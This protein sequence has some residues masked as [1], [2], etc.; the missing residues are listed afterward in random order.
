MMSEERGM[1]GKVIRGGGMKD[2]GGM[3]GFQK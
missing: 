1:K 2:E 3:I